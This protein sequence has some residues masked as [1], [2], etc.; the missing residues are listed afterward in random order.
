VRERERKR[1]REKRRENESVCTENAILTSRTNKI[2]LIQIDTNYL[3]FQEKSFAFLF[4]NKHMYILEF[5]CS[6][7]LE[8]QRI[9]LR[10]GISMWM[11]DD[12][13]SKTMTIML[14]H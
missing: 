13:F 11:I 5:V 10:Y 1:K 4:S 2:I 3:R 6:V 8:K 14:L 9:A 7:L 12:L